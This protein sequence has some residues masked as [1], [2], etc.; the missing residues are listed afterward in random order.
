MK[1]RA[2]P[3]R[4]GG[5]SRED[6][7]LAR[8]LP[9]TKAR[10]QFR[11]PPLNLFTTTL[12]EYPSQHYGGS[13]QGDRNYVGATP[14]WVIWQCLMRWTR[15]GELVVDPMC[16]SGTT[17]DV[18]RDLKR[19]CLGFDL[20]SHERRP[21]IRRADARSLPV[22]GGKADFVFVDP[23]YSTH[24]NYSEDPRCIGKLGALADGSGGRSGNGI[25]PDNEYYRAM[26]RSI[27]EM[28][29]ILKPGGHL[30]LYVSDSF[31]KDAGFAP[32]GFHL[33]AILCEFFEPVDII[34][35]VRRNASLDKGNFRRAA[36]EG[37]FMMR[38]FN[39]LF[40][41]RKGSAQGATRDG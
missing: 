15:E 17:I 10:S 22:E 24:V 38:G 32:I 19:R 30:A 34:S 31:K 18:C 1:R 16:G 13:I 37:A 5:A 39:Y 29:R 28:H 33:F 7:P 4:A 20:A 21:D 6:E 36:E 26:R 41:M 14:S 11:K 3:A 40:V 8:P 27:A 12:W 25:V 9:S 23:P 35:A 2:P